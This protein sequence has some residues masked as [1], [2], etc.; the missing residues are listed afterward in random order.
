VSNTSKDAN[1]ILNF[2]EHL[3][4]DGEHSRQAAGPTVHLRRVG[5][6]H[7]TGNEVSRIID[8]PDGHSRP[9]RG[10]QVSISPN[11]FFLKL[12]QK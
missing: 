11:T 2:P 6:G 1:H 3:A 10:R 12:L 5:D 9:I 4:N 8:E 7:V